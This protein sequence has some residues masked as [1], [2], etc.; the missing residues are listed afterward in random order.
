MN[1][2]CCP[3][4]SDAPAYD[5][6]GAC[7]SVNRGRW[8]TAVASEESKASEMQNQYQDAYIIIATVVVFTLLFAGKAQD[9]YER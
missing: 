9:Y 1:I 4:N 7:N 5:G 2:G 8:R 3:G 6:V